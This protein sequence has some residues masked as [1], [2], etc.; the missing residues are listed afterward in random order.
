[1]SNYKFL[2]QDDLIGRKEF[3]KEWV[4]KALIEWGGPEIK[5]VLMPRTWIKTSP[6][7]TTGDPIYH[8]DKK[9]NKMKITPDF[10]GKIKRI[11]GQFLIQVG[12][13]VLIA[14]DLKTAAKKLIKLAEE[15]YK[16]LDDAPT[17]PPRD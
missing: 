15:A 14:P 5:P 1:M 4:D 12:C 17:G 8:K 16:Q 10:I 6:T 2:A 3:K 7:F 11:D 9:E 13:K